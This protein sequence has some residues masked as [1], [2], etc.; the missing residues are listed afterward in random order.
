MRSMRSIARFVDARNTAEGKFLSVLLSVLLV[1]SFLNVT[2]F[3]ERAGAD[4]TVE[5]TELVDQVNDPVGED[6]V[7]SEEPETE[8]V[9]EEE[10]EVAP[11][12]P[13]SDE[14]PD[15]APTEEEPEADV[16]VPARVTPEPVVVK[17]AQS[18]PSVTVAPEPLETTIADKRQ[19]ESSMTRVYVFIELDDP[20]NNLG[21]TVGFDKYYTIGYVE[22][23]S[24]VLRPAADCKAGDT[25][26]QAAQEKIEALVNS[27]SIHRL[28][29]N[30]GMEFD[31][32]DIT[33]K[34]AK[35]QSNDSGYA[36]EDGNLTWHL[37]GKLTVKA[38]CNVTVE[39][40]YHNEDGEPA[41]N[42]LPSSI[43]KTVKVGES[44]TQVT[45][46]LKG[47]VADKERV[48]IEHVMGNQVVTVTYHKDSN[49]NGAPD[50]EETYTVTYQSGEHG[51]FVGN[52]PAEVVFPDILAGSQTPAPPSLNAELG[53]VFESWEP[54][55]ANTVT[56]DA[57]YVAQW[58][59]RDDLSYTVRY[60]EKGTDRE[61]AEALTIGDKSFGAK[62]E[63]AALSIKGY[64]ADVSTKSLVIGSNAADIEDNVITFYY[65]KRADVPYQVQHYQQKLDG[66]YELVGTINEVGTTDAPVKA[67][68]KQ[69][70]GFT[71]N[72]A[73]PGTVAEGSIAADGSLVL[74]LYYDRNSYRVTYE[75][76]GFV[77]AGAS[78]LPGA[79]D[80]KYGETIT[81]ADEAEAL[82]YKFSGWKADGIAGS[83][84]EMP[85]Q[86]VTLKGS[87][88][89]NADT[90]YTVKRYLENLDGTYPDEATY[91]DVETKGTTG[92]SVEA[93]T[94]VS[95][96]GFVF[97]TNN[98]NNKLEGSI[99]ADG[100][101]VLKVYYKRAQHKVSYRYTG[102]VPAAAPAVPAPEDDVKYKAS[103]NVAALPVLAGYT[104]KGWNTT[105]VVVNAGVFAMPNSAVEFTG[106]WEANENTAYEVEYYYMK[107]GKYAAVADSTVK[108]TGTTD[109]VATVADADKNPTRPGYRFDAAAANVESAPIAG[110]GST[111]LKVYFKQ[112]L[113]VS[114]LP[115]DHGVFDQ[116][117]YKE[118][119]YGSLTPAAPLVAGE[120]G[121]QFEGWAPALD[122]KVTADASYE[123]QWSEDR[124]QTHGLTVTVRY[125]LDNE[126][127]KPDIELDED[128]NVISD[129]SVLFDETSWI[130]DALTYI[131]N[132]EAIAAEDKFPGY[133]R[134][135]VEGL[136]PSYTLEAA[137]A[138]E[139]EG[140]TT[141]TIDV[142]YAKRTDLRYTVQYYLDGV[143]MTDVPADWAQGETGVTFGSTQSVN[144]EPVVRVDDVQ[145]RLTST[146][147]AIEIG[148]DDNNNV[149][150]VDYEKINMGEAVFAVESLTKTYDG[151]PLTTTDFTV[152]GL[153]RAHHATATVTGERTN[154][155][156]TELTI[157]DMRIFDENNVDVTNN[158]TVLTVPGTLTVEPRPVTI[159]VDDATKLLGMTDPAFTGRITA[160]SLVDENDLGLVTFART[161]TDQ[162]AGVYGGVLTAN[163]T[164][165][166]N[167]TVTVVPGD[168][169]IM[170]PAPLP[171][172]T[173]GTPV[174]PAPV[175]TPAP[176]PAPAPAPAATP[177]AATPA[178]PAAAVPAAAAPAPA[179]A[180]PA[181]T[182]TTIDDDAAPLA[183]PDAGEQIADDGT[184]MGAFDE[185]HCWVHWAMLAGILLT[186]LYG[187]VV[188]RRRLGIACDIDDYE[189]EI[190]GRVEAR[191][192]APEF[193]AAHQAL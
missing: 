36:D 41:P 165:N 132:A 49:G 123:A 192:D 155:G 76:D 37:D 75:Y 104:F 90:K 100:S 32:E 17:Q 26:K 59:I 13:S 55:V 189:N 52:D 40:V 129:S 19:P 28:P 127:V 180:T 27:G 160:G 142:Y 188:V 46:F 84:F 153:D 183:A 50:C 39:Y 92:A 174:P 124:S 121:Y 105:D 141:K 24:D 101:L 94:S 149:I 61:L 23:S 72:L 133:N 150:R 78:A 136:Q 15:P 120:V 137:E 187:L 134:V 18:A 69:Y 167:Y 115:G 109:A 51:S 74:K 166:P 151:E 7:S 82:G 63:A 176:T 65:T 103:V 111:T 56:E 143:Q 35:V 118:L 182:T 67:Q 87:W 10:P 170:V 95:Y 64:E 98:A 38:K 22:L 8:V 154:V 168:F 107:D 148:V 86:N 156:T 110:D 42:N 60:L 147:H 146:D 158:Y 66:S 138:G 144:P 169:T 102:V 177:A 113:T 106:A 83:E 119:D 126:P 53:W 190:T 163:Y 54:K 152:A 145:Y 159:T 43:T 185:P 16:E 81:V 3:T 139:F 114:Y 73:A 112:Q 25:A 178:A 191:A 93:D 88:T 79:V 131:P 45:P 99:A 20:S 47:Y 186:V 140:Q 57:T 31:Y 181:P 125:W 157:S 108:R 62:V 173:P 30:Q 97:D 80:Y 116:V 48:R 85:A 128:G 161:N 14:T 89:A 117:T 184:P 77:P 44:F 175:P 58:K 29:L 96:E 1:F 6:P 179:A 172:P 34:T 9:P 71:L 11:E 193:A 91:T 12:N 162:V 130:N 4:E 68:P 70:D 5:S 171:T 21:G 33:W 164:A 2:M 135:R 122:T